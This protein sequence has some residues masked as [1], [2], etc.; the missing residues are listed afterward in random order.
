MKIPHPA[1]TLLRLMR[2]AAIALR[3]FLLGVVVAASLL[4]LPVGAA[5][6]GWEMYGP[7]G[8]TI[9]HLVIAPGTSTTLYANT[10][11]GNS[12]SAFRSIDGGQRWSHINSGPQGLNL[13]VLAV[14]P[15]NPTN[16]YAAAIV[17]YY[18]SG[19][20]SPEN[21]PTAAQEARQGLYKSSDG[22]RTWRQ[23]SLR[24]TT[25]IAIDP[26]TPTT[27]YTVV[28]DGEIVRS[29]DGGARW[30]S[31]GRIGNPTVSS[32]VVDPKTPTMIYAGVP[33]SSDRGGGVLKSTD[34]GVTWQ[35]TALRQPVATLAI[36]PRTSTTLYAGTYGS[37]IFKSV[38]A[39]ST[40]RAATA[41]LTIS[42]VK[43]L[44]V[45]PQRPEIIYAASGAEQWSGGGPGLFKTTDGGGTWRA[46]DPHPSN[47]IVN[48]LVI[49]PR[50][51]STLYIGTEA[52]GIFKSTDAGGT[53]RDINAGLHRLFVS[54]IAIGPGRPPVLYAA[55]RGAGVFKSTDGARTWRSVNTGLTTFSIGALAINPSTP[56]TLY[57]GT[58]RGIFKSTNEGARWEMVSAGLPGLDTIVTALIVDPREPA[59]LYAGSQWDVP[60]GLGIYKSTD[61]GR[62]WVAANTGLG[63]C[64]LIYEL[65]ADPHTRGTIYARIVESAGCSAGSG[66]F[67]SEDGGRTW[68]TTG[69][70]R[71]VVSGLAIDPKTPATLYAISRGVR[72]STDGGRTWHPVG[73]I[74]VKHEATTLSIDPQTPTTIYVATWSKG[75]FKSTDGGSAWRQLDPPLTLPAH[76]IVIDP[77]AATIYAGTAEGIAVLRQP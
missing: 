73:A 51:P 41:G 59:T 58:D 42:I 19:R 61:G 5:S 38:D 28:G 52:G 36:D 33:V 8:G 2:T 9:V 1:P 57:V 7:E 11:A 75:I 6:R 71:A 27:I 43:T 17:P 54:R 56:A 24:Y 14:D 21:A 16:V 25:V 74:P 77:H 72:R 67:K 39:G 22:G 47:G 23:I 70:T 68:R 31:V 53:W 20:D 10:E 32:L 50:T 34:S 65:R 35:T 37:G 62:T 60:S 64:R 15:Q 3:A 29:T 13:A 49:D 63:G 18:H 55:V 4:P 40:W 44:A 76:S 66:L 48:A 46:L 45:D 12:T 26:R 30:T 69:L